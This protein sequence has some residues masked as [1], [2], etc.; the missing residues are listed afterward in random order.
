MKTEKIEE[1]TPV[2]K[3]NK[4]VEEDEILHNI[5]NHMSKD[6]Q[7]LTE[8]IA[9][10]NYCR[11]LDIKDINSIPTYES[12]AIKVS[13]EQVKIKYINQIIE[14]G[15]EVEDDENIQTEGLSIPSELDIMKDEL[16]EIISDGGF[17]NLIKKIE[18]KRQIEKIQNEK[19][20][21]MI[22]SA[23]LDLKEKKQ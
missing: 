14:E 9:F 1:V 5:F 10:K 8:D 15:N 2:E 21:E 22:Y 7:K 4:I 18:F 12:R 3:P 13:F 11:Y 23:Y 20:F 17:L 19:D 6:N 16:I